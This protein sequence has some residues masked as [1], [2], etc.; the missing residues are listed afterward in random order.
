VDRE[1]KEVFVYCDE[2]TRSSGRGEVHR[3][4]WAIASWCTFEGAVRRCRRI[5]KAIC[6]IPRRAAPESHR[7]RDNI[8]FEKGIH[9]HWSESFVL[10]TA[11]DSNETLRNEATRYVGKT[12]RIIAP[13]KVNGGIHECVFNV[14]IEEIEVRRGKE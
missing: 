3:R 8:G 11:G 10:A 1:G 2:Q 4:D 13:F 9:A 12:V 14:K 5:E 7:S 6:H